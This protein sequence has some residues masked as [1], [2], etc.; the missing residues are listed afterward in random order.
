MRV[1]FKLAGKPNQLGQK[2]ILC[3]IRINGTEHEFRTGE[4]TK[5][6]FWQAKNKTYKVL[7][8]A[9]ITKKLQKISSDLNDSKML[10]ELTHPKTLLEASQIYELYRPKPQT[11]PLVEVVEEVAPL[12]TIHDLC[13]VFLASITTTDKMR[14]IL[15]RSLNNVILP[16]VDIKKPAKDY[17]RK[18][19]DKIAT[20]YLAT[21]HTHKEKHPHQRTNYVSDCLGALNRVFEWCEEEEIIQKNNFRITPIT[22]HQPAP[23]FMELEEVENFKNFDFSKVIK[24]KKTLENWETTRQIFLFCCDTGLYPSDYKNLVNKNGLEV[25]EIQQDNG[26]LYWLKGQRQK[27]TGKKQYGYFELKLFGYGLELWKMLDGSL[28]ALPKSY[29]FFLEKIAKKTKIKEHIT[30]KLARDTFAHLCLNEYNLPEM[31]ICAMLGHTDTKMLKK[32]ARISNKKI[33]KDTAHL[34]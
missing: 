27:G 33:M 12:P 32:Y 13:K 14:V 20:D 6:E 22:R 25:I 31:T 9:S 11:K 7:N 8:N 18:D 5:K 26:I 29:G 10:L 17:K 34:H 16:F 1:T 23:D 15:E 28:P 3:T 24:N 2:A 30:P 21:P 4:N 19:F